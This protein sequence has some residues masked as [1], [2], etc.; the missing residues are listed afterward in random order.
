MRAVLTLTPPVHMFGDTI[1]AR[2]AVVADTKFVDPRLLRVSTDF[3]PYEPIGPPTVKRVSVGRFAQA[4]WTWSLRCLTSPCVPRSP[5]SDKHRQFQFSPVHIDYPPGHGLDY[6]LTAIWQPI[7]VRSAI[8]PAVLAYLGF[9]NKI[10]WSYV[11]TPFA[12]PSYSASPTL[13]YRLALAAA[14]A[15]LAAAA[16]LAASWLRR[17]WPRRRAE[18][19]G[20]PA[21]TPLEQALG[22]LAWAGERGDET[23]QRKALERVADELTPVA[24]GLVDR[25]REVAWSAPPPEEAEVESLSEQARALGAPHPPEEERP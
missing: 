17:I 8:S 19:M 25:V 9:H 14:I 21:P 13:L 24:D 12:A 23:T 18:D 7:E 10:L 11:L 5:P 20:A 16:L 4:T 22:L 2:V 6:H 3:T 15:A 1:T